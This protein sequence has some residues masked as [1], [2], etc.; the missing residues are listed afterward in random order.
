MDIPP[1]HVL[2]VVRAAQALE[3]TGRR[4][5]HLEVGQPSTPAPAL[6]RQAAADVLQRDLLGYTT[7]NGIEALR[8][9]IARHYGERHDV[10][11]DPGRIVL[12]AG[13]SGG[14][15]LAFLAAFEHGERVAVTEPGYPCYRN[16]LLAFDR[17]PVGVPVGSETRFQP[18]PALLD[19]VAAGRGDRLAG[20]VV[21]SPSNPTGSALRADELAAL[22]GWCSQRSVR[23]VADE[24][25]HG[26]AFGSAPPTALSV[27]DEAIVLNSFSKYFSM[28]GWRLGWM[29]VPP[30]LV[31][32]V[33]R[34]AANLFICPSVLSQH[35]ALAAFEATDELEGHVHRYAENRRIVLDGLAA[36][37][38]TE[39]APAD[40][41]FY[42]YADVHHLGATSTEL[43]RRWLDELGVAATPGIDFDP[44]RGERFVRFCYAG[45]AEDLR[46]AMGLLRSWVAE[47]QFRS[48]APGS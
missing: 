47:N 41:A 30:A 35:A 2:E 43:C 8:R 44:V 27:S 13:A 18:T 12:T 45:A 17:V 22:A 28:T 11:V 21:A 14:F 26:I 24:I 1:F 23:L 34:L 39:V 29:V 48:P 40:G 15:V 19:A 16:T 46:E 9:R 5:L 38:I 4:V 42:A 10:D 36:A 31:G 25:Y 6:A 3:A 20:L 33:D 37:G 32:P 7:A